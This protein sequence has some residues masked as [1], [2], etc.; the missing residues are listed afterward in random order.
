MPQRREIQPKVL[1]VDGTPANLVAMKAVLKP[2]G[3]EIVEAASGSQALEVA[4]EHPSFAVALIDVQMPQ[5]DGFELA[6][7]LRAMPDFKELPI[8]FV[9]AIFRDE[10]YVHEGYAA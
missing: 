4:A 8:I 1:V 5:M 9:T 10:R 2:I 3:V 7:R 6:A